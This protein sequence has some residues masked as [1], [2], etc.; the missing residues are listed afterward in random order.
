MFAVLPESSI[1]Y[2]M[3]EEGS[4]NVVFINC[5]YSISYHH[6]TAL[7]LTSRSYQMVYTAAGKQCFL[8]MCGL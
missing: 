4:A 2:I 1:K 7:L 6:N 8:F 5:I 3:K